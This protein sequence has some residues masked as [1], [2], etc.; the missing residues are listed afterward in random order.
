MDFNGTLTK[1]ASSLVCRGPNVRKFGE[2]QEQG[3]RQSRA[4][5]KV[6]R[7]KRIRWS[8]LEC[9]DRITTNVP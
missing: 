7:V 6:L 9:L 2:N 5:D 3:I 8:Q 4:Q 1:E